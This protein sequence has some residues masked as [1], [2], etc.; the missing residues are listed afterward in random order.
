MEKYFYTY[1]VTHSETG[2]YYYG[3]RV[4][5]SLPEDDKDYL[6]SPAVWNP[7]KSK[8]SKEILGEWEDE[9]EALIEEAKLVRKH[10]KNT[11]N[12]N[13]H[14]PNV[15]FNLYK[16]TSRKWLIETYGEEKGLERFNQINEKRVKTRMKND[17][18][19]HSKESLEKIKPTMW[20]K[21]TKPWNTGKELSEEHVKNIKKTWHSDKRM[22]LMQSE[23][24]KNKMSKALSGKNHP[25]YGKKKAWI[26]N[27]KLKETKIIEEKFL[28]N[29]INNGWIKG[30]KKYKPWSNNTINRGVSDSGD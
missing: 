7:D 14:I 22:K 13:Y 26:S 28:N 2:E 8:L 17:G 3:S 30:R 1:K 18:Y 27:D 6:G 24:Y 4:S 25:Q 5:H 20:K 9:K 11:L 10:I 15:K 16:R 23:S 12:R 29:Y 21:G 19:K